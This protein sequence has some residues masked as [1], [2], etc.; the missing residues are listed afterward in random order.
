MGVRP[1]LRIACHSDGE[2]SARSFERVSLRRS[3]CHAFCGQA[4]RHVWTENPVSTRL[5]C[6]RHLF[7][8]VWRGQSRQ[9][10]CSQPFKILTPSIEPNTSMRLASACRPWSC[11]SISC[12]VRHSRQLCAPRTSSDDGFHF[13]RTRGTGRSQ[14]GYITG[15]CPGRRLRV[16]PPRLLFKQRC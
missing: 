16:R 15:W 2:C 9:L 6:I 3:Q 13:S 14:H 12:S 5:D 1:H 7:H 11:H 4:G 10:C 8:R